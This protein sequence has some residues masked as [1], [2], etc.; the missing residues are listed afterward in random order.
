MARCVTRLEK[1]DAGEIWLGDTDIAQTIGADLRPFRAGIQ[2]IFQDPITSMNPKMSAV[3]IIE[4]PWLIQRRGTRSE[5]STRAAE[6]IKEVGLSPDWLDRRI[7]EFSGGQQQ[8]IAIA[9]ALMLHPKV[10]VLD[11]AL[12]GLDI[13]TQVEIAKLLIEIQR[14]QS[15]TYLLISHDLLLVAHMADFV[16]VMADGNIVE[17]GPVTEIVSNPK[18]PETQRLVRVGERFRPVL[19]RAQ[20]ASA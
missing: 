20:G 3:E 4:E 12:S 5:R 9:R 8:R 1:P 18:H 14:T 15:L 2:M 13:C 19:A 17:Q 6:L 11:E 10:L 7:T 16:A